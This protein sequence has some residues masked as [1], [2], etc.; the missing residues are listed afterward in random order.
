MTV[1]HLPGDPLNRFSN[2]NYGFFGFFTAAL[3]FVFLSGLVAG[4]VYENHRLRYG[5]RSTAG[6]ILRRARTLYATQVVLLVVLLIAVVAHFE[7]V[8]RWHLDLFGSDPGKGVVFGAMLLYEPG[9][10]GILPMYILFLL[11]TPLILWSFHKGYLW[12]VLGLSVLVWIT[13]GLAVRLPEDSGGVDFG[14]FNPLAY[15][16]LFVAGLAFGT[17]RINLARLPHGVRSWMI[18]SAILITTLFFVAR[19]QYALHGPLNPLLDRSGDWFS[20]VE[21]GPLRLLNFA[22][23]ALVLHWVIGKTEWGKAGSQP[24]RW[25]AFVGRH[26]LPVFAWSILATYAAVA[27]FPHPGLVLGAV[28][29]ALVTISLTIP[30]KLHAAV[31]SRRERR[32]RLRATGMARPLPAATPQS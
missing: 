4:L 22:A 13:S 9:Y 30:A 31:M 23:F 16:L 29:I 27:L 15:Q 19:E 26:S 6:R 5:A 3:G 12:H 20:T 10:L 11:L 7:G 17:G 8:G 21:L 28:G 32:H 25:L 18:G 2:P 24:F 1:D 14:A